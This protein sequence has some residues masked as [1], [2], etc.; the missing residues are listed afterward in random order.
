MLLE[1]AEFSAL[2]LSRQY[3]KLWDSIYPGQT[4][5]QILYVITY[6][7]NLKKTTN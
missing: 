2:L 6:A 3:L 4:E 7:W 1:S 5:I